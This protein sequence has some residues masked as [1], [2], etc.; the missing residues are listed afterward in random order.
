V[1]ADHT[2]NL[3]RLINVTSGVVVSLAGQLGV[4]SPFSDGSGSLATFSNPA[5]VSFNG[6]GT[7]AVI[8]SCLV[9]GLSG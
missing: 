5:G 6:A 9:H 1:Q 7:F 3:I 4:S 8:V 2:N